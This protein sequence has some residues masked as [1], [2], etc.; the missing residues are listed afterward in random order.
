MTEE[1]KAIVKASA[2]SV[3]S[4]VPPTQMAGRFRR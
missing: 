4:T 1:M 2:L 3:R